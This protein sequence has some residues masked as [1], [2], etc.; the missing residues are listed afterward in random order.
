MIK[1]STYDGAGR[2]LSNMSL[3]EEVEADLN[4]LWV[5]GH[6][7]SKTSFIDQGVVTDRP[8]LS[9]PES[10]SLSV[11]QEWTLPGIP[12][13]T[14]VVFDGDENII[15]D[16]SDLVLSFPETG[17]WSVT[18]SPPFP[19]LDQICEVTVL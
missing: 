12:S 18:F 5:Y 6:H 13:G 1:V 4:G 14:V 3:R 2:I 16:G 10:Y 17:T 7:S 11:E 8:A 9:V 15:A 19:Y